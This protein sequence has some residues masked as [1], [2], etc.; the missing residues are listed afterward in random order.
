[1]NALTPAVS[2]IHVFQPVSRSLRNFAVAAN[3][4]LGGR[5]AW[6]G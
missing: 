2:A 5:K 6:I 1:V 3:L 4:P